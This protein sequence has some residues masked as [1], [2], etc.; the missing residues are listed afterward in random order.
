MS[1]LGL[2][3]ICGQSPS[4]ERGRIRVIKIIRTLAESVYRSP[5]PP[6]RL[7]LLLYTVGV[8]L[9]VGPVF[10][11]QAP[12]FLSSGASQTM[13]AG[14]TAR[15]VDLSAL[16]R[17]PDV[18]GTVVRVSVRIGTT[19]KP[20]DIALYDHDKPI[21]VANFLRYVNDGKYAGSF[22]HRSVAGFVVQGGGFFWNASGQIAAIPT[23]SAIQNEPGISNL[24]GTVAMAKLGGDANSATSQ[25]FV[26]LA[27]NSANLDAQNGGFTVFGRV[28]GSGMSVIDEVAALPVYN[29]GS[30]LDQLPLKDVTGTTVQRSFTV[31]TSASV[32]PALSYGANSADPDLVAVSV[33]GSTLRLTPSATRSGSTTVTFAATDL[34]GATTQATLTVNVLAKSAGWQVE[35]GADGQPS[36]LAFNP[37]DPTG[38]SGD[39][40]PVSWGDT[41]LRAT[42]SRTITLRNDGP[43]SLAGLALINQGPQAADFQITRGLGTTTLGPGSSTSFTVTFAPGAAGARTTNLRVATSDPNDPSFALAL[44]GTGFDF[45]RPVIS[46]V[47]RETLIAD[48]SDHGT[49]PDWR[50]TVVTASDAG[51]IDSFTQSPAPGTT[52]TPGAYPLVFSAT[53]TQGRAITVS[54]DLLV[55][56]SRPDAPRAQ[57]T[58]AYGGTPVP[59]DGGDGLPSGSTLTAFGTPAI[60]DF[61]HL[62]ARVTIAAGAAR[63]AAIYFEDGTGQSKLVARQNAP[64]GVSGAAFKTFKDP[65]VSPSG[66]VAFCAT[67]LGPKATEDEGVWSDLF[68]SLAPVLRE[69]GSLPGLS[70]LKLSSVMSLSLADDALLALVKLTPVRGYVVAGVSDIALIRVTGLDSGT[71]LARTGA[72]FSASTIKLISV[73]QPAAL[74][75]GQ[76]RWQSAAATVAKFTLVTG[77]TVLVRIA[78]DGTQTQLLQAGADDPVFPAR[79]AGL[80]LPALGGSGVAVLATKAIKPGVTTTNDTSILFAPTG[81]SFAE[82]VSENVTAGVPGSPKFASFSDPVTNARGAILF[83]GTLRAGTGV[84]ANLG[85]L[86][87]TDGASPPE[88]VAR[89]GAP[90]VD[91]NGDAIADTTWSAFSSFALP[92]GPGAG[93]LFVAQLAGKAVKPQEK[94][95]L[96]A[97]DSTGLTRLLLRTGG[98]VTLPSGEKTITAFTILN[99]LP[100]SFGARR[101]Y[102]SSGSV[103]VQV[104]FTNLS[105]AIL[106]LDVP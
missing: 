76:G 27:D 86:W 70:D 75:P 24:R 1:S 73:L 18:L 42:S 37:A 106:R 16:F 64:S 4:V 82:A 87:Q 67:L 25:W 8:L 30:P 91:K 79:L 66:K 23:Y 29:A 96:W 13:R 103:A 59:A 60:S 74:S 93:A 71:L 100:G 97:V 10:G 47:T 45:P 6:R 12:E 48:A 63:L 50:G 32:V 101:S 7:R 99:A 52:L 38:L 14:G 39:A 22:F 49:V 34:D 92:D 9:A 33:T 81:G 69:G 78:N 15:D 53:N 17:D 58:G 31:E 84:G 56:Y 88:V 36:T 26:N 46:G 65:I 11:N 62:A 44:T 20:V 21:T 105:Q 80:G 104:T 19:T 2:Q 54:S 72:G 55:L 94:L 51:G 89:I 68:G 35:T 85:A 98:K 40:A 57:T 28:L 102:N 90:A 83:M 77:R 3:D 41:D 95:G 43:A 5:M 61:R